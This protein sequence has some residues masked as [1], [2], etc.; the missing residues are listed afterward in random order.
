[1]KNFAEIV[2]ELQEKH[3]GYLVLVKNGIFYCGIG[4]DAVI[5]NQL[6]GYKPICFKEEK[7]Y[8]DSRNILKLII[9]DLEINY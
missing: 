4:K 6:W 5:M 8:L 3:K 9:E 1:M 7:G 2:K